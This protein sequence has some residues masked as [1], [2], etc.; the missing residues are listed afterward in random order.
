MLEKQIEAEVCEYAKSKNILV[1]KF[2]SPSRTA[3]P[4]RMFVMPDGH[5]WFCEFKRT[6]EKPTPPQTR[7]HL[8]LRGHNVRVFVV[9]NVADGKAMVDQMIDMMLNPLAV[10][11]C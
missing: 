3:V 9:D 7:E 2:T 6:G 10:V 1:Y 11:Q 4:D 8:R 5:V